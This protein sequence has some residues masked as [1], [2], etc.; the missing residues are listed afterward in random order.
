MEFTLGAYSL[1]L[2][3]FAVFTLLL[4][5][6]V[7]TRLS[8]DVRWFGAMML[9]VTVWAAVDGIMVAED[10]LDRMLFLVNFEY[11]GIALVPVFWML[12]V[13]RFVGKDQWLTKPLVAAQFVFPLLTLIMVW[14][15]NLHHLHY[16][17]AQLIEV[18]GLYGL[19]TS[20]GP[21]YI[22]H[23]TYFYSLMILGMVLMVKRCFETEGIYRKQTIIV[24]IGT[25]VPWLANIL[26][27]F[28][29]EP[30]NGFDPTPYGFVITSFIVVF[31][32]LELRLFDVGPIARNKVIDS[33]K[34]GMLVLD[35]ESRMVDFNPRMLWILQKTK[36]ELTGKPFKVLGFK[37]EHW[38]EIPQSQKEHYSMEV[39]M[40]V[41]GEKCYYAV[42][43]K[44]L[45]DGNE[46]IRGRLV[47][48]RDVTQFVMDQQR[49]ELQAKELGELNNTK[50][51][52]LSIIS[53]DMRGPLNTLT[54]FLEMTDAGVIT[55]EELKAMMPRFA[56]NLKH[57][58][59]FLE[60]LLVWAKG[61]LKGENIEKVDFDITIEI[62]AVLELFEA[63]Y[64][65]KGICVNFDQTKQVIVNAD[66][67]MIKLVIRNLL[68]N[69]VK[70]CDS[71]DKIDI[72]LDAKEDELIVSVKDTGVGIE[73]DNIPLIFSSEAFT[74]FGTQKE[75]GT[76]LG[77]MLTKDFVE[78]N[79]GEI[80]VESKLGEGT[81]FCFTVP[82]SKAN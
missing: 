15:N 63:S 75:K 13:L 40:D 73:K 14:T 82:L 24:L 35:V 9:A 39:E 5:V 28:Q 46:D 76:G 12:F 48:F 34:E 3:V 61:Q 6:L 22:I 70:F 2:L 44:L 55:D 38:D 78:K 1:S 33:I 8:K 68:S 17:S 11:V 77:L 51:R 56:E 59:G 36:G 60:N 80:H 64:E 30:F 27:V 20:K 41:R 54:Q 32:F 16:K 45:K 50:D 4:S 72:I 29:V 7:F 52:L 62:K 66:E 67:N 21:W 53:H 81:V 79:G 42:S 25:A 65:N 31:G 47:M 49:L 26:V 43:C 69:A 58:S 57:V 23:T 10:S 71:G 74:T 18:N 19:I 37:G